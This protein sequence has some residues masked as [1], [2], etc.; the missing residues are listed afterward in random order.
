MIQVNCKKLRE[1]A[2]LPCYAHRGDAGLDLYAVD[3]MG[4]GPGEQVMVP[5]GISMAIPEGYAGLVWD[6]SGLAAKHGLTVLAGVIDATY[7]G[8]I[9][10]VIINL[11]KQ[12]F[13]VEKGMRIAQML[14]QPIALA[15]IKELEELDSTKRGEGGFGSTGHR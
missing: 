3:A 9:K 14:I 2:I 5:T 11:G 13:H 10:V 1:D 4:I 6:R 15:E 7:R 8:E 12:P